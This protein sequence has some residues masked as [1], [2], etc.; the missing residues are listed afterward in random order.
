MTDIEE[1]PC[2][3]FELAF[4]RFGHLVGFLRGSFD[5]CVICDEELALLL[6]ELVAV[7]L[8]R[9]QH[10]VGRLRHRLEEARQLLFLVLAADAQL[11]IG[12]TTCAHM[13]T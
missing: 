10:L 9:Q 2:D 7:F 8:A 12:Q 1:Y 3:N 11:S 13:S 6:K 5:A 4:L